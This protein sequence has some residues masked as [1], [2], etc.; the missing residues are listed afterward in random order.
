MNDPAMLNYM[1]S[2][3]DPS[4]LKPYVEEE[5]EYEYAPTNAT[6]SLEPQIEQT[7]VK[8]KPKSAFKRSSNDCINQQTGL[9]NPMFSYVV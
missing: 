6:A 9:Q 4:D 2:L 5:K 3:F 8:D 1:L 7:V